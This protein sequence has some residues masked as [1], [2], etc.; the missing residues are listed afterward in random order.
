MLA[1][2]ALQLTLRGSLLLTK[3]DDRCAQ[4]LT[5]RCLQRRA[6]TDGRFECSP[7]RAALLGYMY[8]SKSMLGPSSCI[9]LSLA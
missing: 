4:R 1:G 9:A 6:A 3:A 2:A 5:L 8:G 7:A